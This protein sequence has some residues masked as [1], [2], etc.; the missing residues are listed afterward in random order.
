MFRLL[1]GVRDDDLFSKLME[2]DEP[3]FEEAQK[4]V[5]T[6]EVANA[7]K[8]NL[9]ET[10]HNKAKQVA[11][12]KTVPLHNSD[13]L[14]TP[15]TLKGRCRGCGSTSHNKKQCSK[16]S[17][18]CTKCDKVGHLPTVCLKPFFEKTGVQRPSDQKANQSKQ[19]GK[20]DKARQVTQRDHS[21]SYSTDSS[22]D[23]E[24]HDQVISTIR[25]VKDYNPH[26][27][28]PKLHLAFETTSGQKFTYPVVPD[29]GATRSIMAL[30]VAREHGVQ[31]DTRT[32]ERLFAANGGIMDC[33]GA[34]NLRATLHG[35]VTRIRCIISAD[36]TDEILIA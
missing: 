35:V 6:W 31:W 4:R 30:N 14:V 36:L 24:I 15:G 16:S 12:K 26:Q 23:E 29:T 20:G 1:T 8:K 2:L 25:A 17:L 5:A 11:A 21:P 32:R 33:R 19:Q 34:V 28:S 7:A 22:D 9:H 10:D 18:V 3:T 27:P 13:G